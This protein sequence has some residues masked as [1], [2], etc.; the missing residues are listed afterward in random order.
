[1]IAGA[2]VGF[3]V[4]TW[5][6]NVFLIPAFLG[7]V[8]WRRHG[9]RKESFVH[10]CWF[11]AACSLPIASF[12]L[13]GAYSHGLHTIRDFS[14]WIMSHGNQSVNG[15]WGSFSLERLMLASRAA[16]DSLFLWPGPLWIKEMIFPVGLLLVMLV[17][18][19]GG[20]IPSLY[21]KA[22]AAHLSG[23]SSCM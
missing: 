12:Y 7:T 14:H 19:G 6:A 8:I 23:C 13:L 16:V 1:M 18:V 5:E 4:T 21:G 10:T 11:L 2:G 9:Q 20:E 22:G 15:M 3:A 17:L